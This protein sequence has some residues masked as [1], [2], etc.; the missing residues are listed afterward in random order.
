MVG[1]DGT[2]GG[3]KSDLGNIRCRSHCDCTKSQSLNQIAGQLPVDTTHQ[4]VSPYWKSRATTSRLSV[5]IAVVVFA[6]IRVPCVEGAAHVLALLG[7]HGLACL[8]AW[9]SPRRVNGYCFIPRK[10]SLLLHV[11]NLEVHLYR[12]GTCVQ[13]SRRFIA[14]KCIIRLTTYRKDSNSYIEYSAVSG[15]KLLCPRSDDF[16]GNSITTLVSSRRLKRA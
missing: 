5:F 11:L 12:A 1:D 9:T 14:Q 7:R 4:P 3:L 2:N 8:L 16:H 6:L 15:S 13:N 10:I